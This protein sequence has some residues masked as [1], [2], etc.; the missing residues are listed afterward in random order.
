MLF[1]PYCILNSVDGEDEDGTYFDESRHNDDEVT[2]AVIS[3]IKQQYQYLLLFWPL[4]GFTYA[5]FFPTK[6]NARWLSEQAF[7]AWIIWHE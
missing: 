2:L 5:T 7:I 3:T 4:L 1:N 6:R